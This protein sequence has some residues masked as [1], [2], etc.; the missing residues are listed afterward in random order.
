MKYSSISPSMRPPRPTAPV[1]PDP[2]PRERT[3]RTFSI[4]SSTMVPTLRR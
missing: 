2:P 1:D 3:S 4:V